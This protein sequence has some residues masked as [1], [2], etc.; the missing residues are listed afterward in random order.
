MSKTL[1]ISGHPNLEQSY[2]NTVIID[3]LS[4]NVS[5]IKVRRLDVLYPDFKI[6]VEAE[7]QALLDA[8]IIVLQFPFYWY[9]V[10]ALLKK[11]I[12]D[13]FSFNF[14]YGPQG[15]KLKGK[16][17]I[18]SFTVGG[19]EESYDP[20]GYNHFEIEQF[21][22]PL[23]QTIYLAGMNFVKPI[24]THRMV[25]IPDVYNELEGVQA[26][27]KQHAE[28]VIRQVNELKYSPENVVKK[29]VANW[30][31]NFDVLPDNNELFTRHLTEDIRLIMPEGEFIGHQGFA[32]WYGGAR[33]TFK[34]N[35]QH[36]V[37]QQSVKAL[38]DN[39]FEVDLRIR[40]IAETYPES[41]LAGQSLNLLVDEKWT[42]TIENGYVAISEY[43]V[44]PIE[45]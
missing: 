43:L 7:Q 44:T 3:E 27:A 9:S 2:T 16:D 30:F 24:Y 22:R 20:L 35:C 34:P 14:A 40:L 36:F 29:F 21:I 41:A 8:D 37:E 19:P 10:P 18:L 15:D 23:Q 31:A 42:L 32:D 11:W 6:N 28:R 33:E 5:D 12:D 1:V 38:K 45:S 13:V 39:Q 26:L 4:F 25:Y 17:I